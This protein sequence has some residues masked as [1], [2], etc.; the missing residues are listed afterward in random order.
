MYEV[1]PWGKIGL[2]FVLL[3]LGPWVF[4]IVSFE[5]RN[6]KFILFNDFFLFPW[7]SVSL[8]NKE[9]NILAKPSNLD[10]KL[11]LKGVSGWTW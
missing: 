4:F 1:K 8:G 9:L 7:L 10:R 3:L 5:A 2:W 6:L 11:V